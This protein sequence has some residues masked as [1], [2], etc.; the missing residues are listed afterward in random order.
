MLRCNIALAACGGNSQLLGTA[1]GA[2][3]EHAA[4]LAA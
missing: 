2:I 3:S 1:N 4:A